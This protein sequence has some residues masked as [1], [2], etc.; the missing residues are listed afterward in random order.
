MDDKFDDGDEVL[1]QV[2]KGRLVGGITEEEVRGV[3]VETREM[4]H[5]IPHVRAD[6]VV[7][8]LSRVDRHLHGDPPLSEVLPVL[9]YAL[10]AHYFQ[11]AM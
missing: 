7:P 5:E 3:P 4:T 8:P 6:P 2:A 9:A 10:R 1:G 11:T